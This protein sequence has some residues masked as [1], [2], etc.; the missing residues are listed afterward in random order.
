M[1]SNTNDDLRDSSKKKIYQV[2]EEAPYRK[3]GSNLDDC[4]YIGSCIYF[5]KI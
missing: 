5:Y 4:P 3:T 1:S 2:Q